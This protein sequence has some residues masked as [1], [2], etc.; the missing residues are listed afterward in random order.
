[1]FFSNEARMG[2]GEKFSRGTFKI[3]LTV[4]AVVFLQLLFCMISLQSADSSTVNVEVGS[5][6]YE[7]LEFLSAVG[8]LDTAMIGALP[9][10]RE[11]MARLIVEARI[12]AGDRKP[13]STMEERVIERLE[14]EFSE[15]IEDLKTGNDTVYFKPVREV[16]LEYLHFDQGDSVYAGPGKEVPKLGSIDARQKAFAYN[17]EGFAYRKDNVV[18]TLNTDGR[19]KMFSFFL[20]PLLMYR[21]GPSGD[22]HSTFQKYYV[23]FGSKFEIQF[24]QDSKWW[25]QGRHGS[26]LLSNNAEPLMAV[27]LRNARPF[28]L[29][30]LGLF[31]FETFLSKLE[32]DRD[33]DRPYFWGLRFS[34]KPHPLFELGLHRTAIFGGSG[35]PG[36]SFGDVLDIV[37]GAKTST[38][39]EDLSNQIAG[40]DFRAYLPFLKTS[41]YGE[42]AGEDVKEGYRYPTKVA[43]ILGAYVADLFGYSLRMEYFDSTDKPGVWYRQETWTDGYTF[44]AKVIGHHAGG[45]AEDFFVEVGKEISDHVALTGSFDIEI[46][47]TNQEVREKHWQYAGKARLRYP[48]YYGEIAGGWESVDNPGFSPGRDENSFAVI[49]F[50]RFF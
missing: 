6:V 21:S 12:K 45:D 25:G 26:L 42:Y 48:P 33:F 13:L 16:E 8:L 5:P 1:M 30:L 44:K 43:Y 32:D 15:D 28:I 31:Q 49:K 39:D 34:F 11:E 38:G 20:Q 14:R 36:L 27:S 17:M 50:K 24:G 40:F 41:L 35:R 22:D 3:C 37:F 46:R 23:K 29:P 9:L 10:S 18:T 7:D 4:F 47:G 2:G 19:I